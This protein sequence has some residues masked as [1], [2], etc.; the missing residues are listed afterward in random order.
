LTKLKADGTGLVWSTYFSG[1][2]AESI[3]NL[4]LA[5][6]GSLWIAG[7]TA[8]LDLP[9]EPP[10]PPGCVPVLGRALPYIARISPD[11]GEVRDLRI[12][13]TLAEQGNRFFIDTSG[14]SVFESS[15]GAPV[16]VTYDRVASLT[17]GPGADGFC[18]L[19]PAD[20]TL[21][22]EVAPGQLVT[23]FGNDLDPQRT[24]VLLDGSPATILYNSQ[25]QINVQTPAELS[26]RSAVTITIVS[27]DRSVSIPLAVVRSSPAAFLS[28]VSFAVDNPGLACGGM[29]I[30]P[31]FLPVA[32]ND[33]GTANSCA[34]PAPPG[35]HVTLYFNGAGLQPRF[36]LA[37]SNSFVDIESAQVV[38]GFPAGF[39]QLRLRVSDHAS[40]L[41]TV[42]VQI[43]GKNS[44]VSPL[45]LVVGN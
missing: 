8:S 40:G 9:H 32:D 33:D 39:W 30:L 31:A 12:A 25:Q 34:H 3:S 15:T 6:D 36:S 42:S 20:W 7:F 27:G 29:A 24:T 5:S 19:D 35:S 28:G 18:L 14:L 17:W 1:T 45:G 44:R 41:G 38:P 21:L 16:G 13:W 37:G 26:D 10:I 11:G 22:G 23:V 4:Q 43:D 2:G